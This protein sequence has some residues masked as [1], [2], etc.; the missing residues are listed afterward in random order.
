MGAIHFAHS[1]FAELVQDPIWT[2]G[3][4]NHESIRRDYTGRRRSFGR[5]AHPGAPR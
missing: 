4:V 3:L 5:L 1:P 2:N